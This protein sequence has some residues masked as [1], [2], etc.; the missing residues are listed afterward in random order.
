MSKDRKNCLCTAM[1]YDPKDHYKPEETAEDFKQHS[2]GYER[3]LRLKKSRFLKA[4]RK[5]TGTESKP[6][7]GGGGGT[8]KKRFFSFFHF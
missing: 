8:A 4:F 6:E 1:L 2:K 7:G 3:L 5:I